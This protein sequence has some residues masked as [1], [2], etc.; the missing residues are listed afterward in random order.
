MFQNS[1]LVGARRF[2]AGIDVS[3]QAVRLVVL[4]RRARLAG[5]L[6]LEY[7]STLPLSAGAMEG[8]EIVDRHAVACALRDVFAGIPRA[9]S[10][11][12]LSCAMALPASATLIST[13]PLARLAAHSGGFGS[14]VNCG[15]DIAALEPVVLIEAERMAG[16]ERHGLS[17]DWFVEERSPLDQLITIAATSR[18][19]LEA[20]V[21]SAIKGGISLST[22]DSEPYAALRAMRFA[23]CHE[24]DPEASYVAIWMGPEGVYGWRMIDGAIDNE[25]RY[26]APEHSDFADALRYLAGV[27]TLSC[28]LIAGDLDLLEGVGFTLNDVSEV[29]GCTVIPFAT[30]A[31][32]DAARPLADA[33]LHDSASAVAFGL[34]LRE[35]LE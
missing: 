6:R 15:R 10:P 1:L 4:S 5:R 19:H 24:I 18:Q 30:V 14:F 17:V 34:A 27:G 32:G 3:A 16:I 7:L 13:L 12:A 9:C 22:L 2:A 25:I 11:H 33:L 8:A 21:E 31:L 35:V 26:P 28:S 29:L 23:A 20:R